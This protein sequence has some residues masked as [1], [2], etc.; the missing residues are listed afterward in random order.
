MKQSKR[1][2]LSNDCILT[3]SIA[4]LKKG[5][6]FKPFVESHLEKLAESLTSKIKIKK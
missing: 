4:A 1:I 5:S 2:E 6:K 3:L